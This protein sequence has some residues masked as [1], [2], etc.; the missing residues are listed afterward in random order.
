MVLENKYRPGKTQTF[1]SPSTH[2][3]SGVCRPAR[4]NRHPKTQEFCPL[5]EYFP[6]PAADKTP[7]PNSFHLTLNAVQAVRSR[8]R[9]VL[10]AARPVYT[11]CGLANV[12]LC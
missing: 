8:R 12:Y 6:R 3:N 5:K 4:R 9:D 2:K 11:V 1:L 7:P 10:S